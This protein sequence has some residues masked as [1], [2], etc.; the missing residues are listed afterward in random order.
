M[1]GP[2][3]PG[4][5]PRYERV[6]STPTLLASVLALLGVGVLAHLLITQVR[7]RRRD[8]AILKAIGFSRRQVAGSVAWEA[9]TLTAITL[10]VALP[11]G[12]AFG[13]WSWQ[14]FANDLGVA[15]QWWCPSPRSCSPSRPGS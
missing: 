11:F 7:S 14:R 6:R 5:V 8:L 9:T 2:Q 15:Q 1:L 13:R 3:K 4:D 12:L 10:V